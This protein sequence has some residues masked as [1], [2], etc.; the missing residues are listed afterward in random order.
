MYSPRVVADSGSP[1]V[2]ADFCQPCRY[3]S[4]TDGSNDHVGGNVADIIQITGETSVDAQPESASTRA[5]NQRKKCGN[6]RGPVPFS[7]QPLVQAP[8]RLGGPFGVLSC[9]GLPPVHPRDAST[10]PPHIPTQSAN[11]LHLG[12]RRSTGGRLLVGRQGG[13]LLSVTLSFVVA[14]FGHSGVR[15]RV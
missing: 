9:R 7:S 12:H 1:R 11:H 14:P 10:S 2:I 13:P 5:P 3:A 8:M 6:M 4:P 15:T